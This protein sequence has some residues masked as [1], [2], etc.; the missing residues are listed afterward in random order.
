MIKTCRQKDVASAWYEQFC[1]NVAVYSG[2]STAT[3]GSGRGKRKHKSLD[4]NTVLKCRFASALYDI[5]SSGIVKC[6]R[7]SA[8]NPTVTI[9]RKIYTWVL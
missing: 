2:A 7:T 1:K 6:S 9:E 8:Q 5:E 3:S 4:S